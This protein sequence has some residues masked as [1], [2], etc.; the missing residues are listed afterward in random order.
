LAARGDALC[1]LARR[2]ADAFD[3]A[4]DHLVA[5]DHRSGAVVGTY[6][7][8]R[9]SVADR[10]GGFYSA[11]EFDLAPLRAHPGELL[12][13]GRSCID[14]R[15]RTGGAVALLWQGLARYVFAH[16]VTLMFGCASLPGADPGRLRDELAYLHAHHLAPP[17][18][19]AGFA[20]RKRLA[21]PCQA[22]VAA[23]LAAAPARP[24]WWDGI[25]ALQPAP[26]VDLTPGG[27][28]LSS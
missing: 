22:Q 3:S 10:R 25:G 2:D 6:R 7:L 4:C 20:D 26:A 18:A 12:E 24:P 23:G 8:L 21:A 11:Q 13:L 14:R 28:V 15:Y 27:R 5:I 1:R 19:A 17:V 16:G 9:R